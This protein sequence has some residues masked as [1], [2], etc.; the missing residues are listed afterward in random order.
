MDAD[1]FVDVVI[2]GEFAIVQ[3]RPHGAE[4]ADQPHR[5]A[6]D[7]GPAFAHARVEDGVRALLEGGVAHAGHLIHE[8][9]I[10]ADSHGDAEGEAGAHA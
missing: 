4:L 2:Q 1:G 6:D 8:I 7:D 3:H 9:G 10:E 5:M